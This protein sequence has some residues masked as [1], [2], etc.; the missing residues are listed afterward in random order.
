MVVAAV[1]LTVGVL[2]FADLGVATARSRAAYRWNHDPA[3][4]ST[5]ATPNEFAPAAT[6]PSPSQTL[7]F[8]EVYGPNFV[9]VDVGEEGDSPGDYGVFRDKLRDVDT[10]AVLGT[11]DVQC[12]AAFADQCRGSIRLPGRGQIT[13]DG[14]TRL[15]HDPDWFAVTGGTK[16]FVGADG[17]VNVSFPS[18]TAARI[19]VRL[20]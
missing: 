2:L 5:A 12:I 6:A 20:D 8:D 9:F 7:E 4:R 16:D 19:T 18:D 17:V 10:G 3:A 11:I 15:G 14:I 1:A 13:F